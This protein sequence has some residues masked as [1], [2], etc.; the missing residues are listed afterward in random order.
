MPVKIIPE[1]GLPFGDGAGAEKKVLEFLKELPTGYYVIRECK[2]DPSRYKKTHGS[3]EDRPDFVVV[4]PSVGV[5]ILEVK[6]W[7]IRL[8]SF[9]PAENQRLIR[10]I[11]L[12]TKVE[13]FAGNPFDQANEYRYAVS[14]VLSKNPNMSDPL[15]V[16]SFVVYPKLTRTEF[17]NQFNGIQGNNPQEQFIFNLQRT[18]FADDLKEYEE[19][20]LKLLELYVTKEAKQRSRLVKRYTDQQVLRTVD[21]L[22][23]SE[24][25]VG[26]LPDDVD[27]ENNLILLDEKQQ[28]WAFSD[29]LVGKIYLSDVAGSGKTNVLLSRAIYK[30]RQHIVAGGCRMLVVTYSKALKIELDRI[31]RS[32][33][34]DDADFNYYHDAIRIYD[35]VT[36]MEEIV[37]ISVGSSGSDFEFWKKQSL[38]SHLE[39]EYIDDVLP[40][41][42]MDY[43]DAR[44]K[45]FQIYDYLF[46]DEIQDFSTWFVE[47]ARMLLKDR[48][49]IF[50]VGDIG[51]KLFERDLDWGELDIVRQR[52]EMQ[53][54]FI[55]YRSPKPIAKLAWKFLI[56]DRFI[57]A[58]LLDEGYKMDV[59]PKSLFTSKPVFISEPSEEELLRHLLDDLHS[60]LEIARPKQFLCIGLKDKMLGNLYR[61]L[62]SASLSVRWATEITSPA[63]DYI[64]LA[65]YVE[66]KGL[67]RDY[68]YILD[69]DFLAGKM[70]PFTSEDEVQKETRRDRIKL[71]VAL[72]RAMREVRL[73]YMDQSHIFIRQLLELQFKM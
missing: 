32:K 9:M 66:A 7:N 64:V 5:M 51:Q 65:D 8:N 34:K 11:D 6:D 40:E 28:E 25:R 63:G 3:L 50:A 31:F 24:M 60:H 39:A 2:V 20:P 58:D 69:S 44:G 38:A 72:T 49:K 26:G 37:K 4:G 30:A 29:R 19:D 59:K 14:G 12:K 48:K 67:E 61:V 22:V 57:E 68:V 47:V 43:L 18:L 10:I 71:F 42:C 15:W 17:E 73:Y 45:E 54:R 62:S 70:G 55:M 56:S 41:R 53:S 27:A 52:V 35:M 23:P 33:I 46:I 16:S 13:S 1:H 21:W 36:L